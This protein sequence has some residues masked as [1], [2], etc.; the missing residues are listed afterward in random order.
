M[1]LY[2]SPRLAAGY[3][4][5]RPPVHRRV[6][7]LIQ[8]R[9]KTIPGA[10][11]PRR[12]ALDIGCGAG[13]STAALSALAETVIGLE[14]VHAM[15]AHCR[16]VAPQAAFLVGQGER[17]PFGDAAFDLMTA[18]GAVNYM[19]L[20]LF[21][22]EVARVLAPDGLLVIYDFSAG[23]RLRADASLDAWYA[24]F[25]R[26]YPSPP[27]YALDVQGL[28]WQVHGL[29]LAAFDPFEIALPMTL[30]SYLPYAMSETSV[31]AAILRGAPEPE[32]QA[33]CRRTLAPIFGES[34][35]DVL[36]D[37]YI[38]CVLSA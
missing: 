34:S 33:W 18:A 22:P 17:L 23:R 2:E 8:E 12:R 16:Q 11:A 31:E 4:F 10:G 1:S 14:P 3:A 26:R 5:N 6:I 29:R 37:G 19:N 15:L 21:L 28:P 32:I 38:S 13:L 20:D 27:G 24:E 7:E 30:A 9:M 35:R 36:F 25:E